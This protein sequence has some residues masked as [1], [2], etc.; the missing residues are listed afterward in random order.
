MESPSNYQEVMAK[1]IAE[2]NGKLEGLTVSTDKKLQKLM[3]II[4]RMQL[5]TWKKE[6]GKEIDQVQKSEEYPPLLK[7]TLLYYFYKSFDISK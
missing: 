5:G 2:I 3:A 6:L 1:S 4:F 7:S